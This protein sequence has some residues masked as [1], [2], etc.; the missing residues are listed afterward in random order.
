MSFFLTTQG[1]RILQIL[2][3]STVILTLFFSV[4]HFSSGELRDAARNSIAEHVKVG[5]RGPPEPKPAN[6]T[7]DFQEIIYLSMPYRTDRQDALSLI[8][9]VSGLKLTMI[10]GSALILEDD[11]DWDVDIRNIMGKFSW[12]LRYNNTLRWGKNVEQ[13]W[14]E[15]CPY[16]CDW[17]EIFVGQCGGKPNQN[18]LDLHQAYTDPASPALSTLQ[19]WL[20]KEFST[21]W[22]ISESANTRVISPTWEPICLMGY[23]LSRM[24]AMRM[25]YNIGGWRPF[26][27]P[28]DNEIAWRT[29]EGVLSGYTLSPPVFTAWRVG[30]SQDSDN[31]AGLNAKPANTKGNIEGYSRNLKN[32]VRKSL[33]EYFKKDF[34]NGMEG[35]RVDRLET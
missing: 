2:V 13:G 27:N 15:D 3:A 29:S 31:D 7:L 14:K 19:P 1:I 22:N 12:Q 25:L 20:Q 4:S 16:G 34:W 24:G 28:V 17:D 23:A 10:P 9:A 35:K 6:A 33:P 32:G 26:G 30:G 11:V 5:S 18:R 21:L 8:A